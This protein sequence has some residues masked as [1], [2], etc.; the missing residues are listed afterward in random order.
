[1]AGSTSSTA[2]LKLYRTFST[3]SAS[4]SPAKS[5]IRMAQQ[6]AHDLP[7]SQGALDLALTTDQP[8]HNWSVDQV[9]EIYNTPLNTLLFYSQL[10]HRK[11][12]DPKE[13]QLCTLLSIKTGGCTEDCKYCAQSTRNHTG[14]KAEKLLDVEKVFAKAKEAK[15]MGSTRFCMGSAWREMKGRKSALR[16]IGNMVERIN[17]E[18]GM[19][20]CVTLGMI[21]DEQAKVLKDAGLT[22]YNHNID[23]SR[24][25]YKDIIST[26]TYDDRLKTIKAV[27]DANIGA[28]AGGILGLGETPQDRVSFLHTL[29]TMSKHPE[30]VPIN[31]LIAIKGT[32]MEQELKTK[33][34]DRKLKMEDIYRTVATARL[35]MPD[36]I[37]RLAAGRYTMR[38]S[39]QL[40]C[41]M[42]GV[43]AIFTGEKMLTTMCTGWEEDIGMLRRWGFVPMESFKKHKPSA[44]LRIKID[45]S[46]KTFDV[47]LTEERQAA[48]M[49]LHA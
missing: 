25:H 1:M 26:R 18:L 10:Q 11:H 24:E 37:V 5:A 46:Q 48:A 14:V 19:E 16:K 20:T 45:P 47:D 6:P 22:A 2:M 23:T 8:I 34:K 28:C 30:S 13:I 35:I 41:F 36:S 9:K 7:P 49:E 4:L 17:D 21:N 43:N 12:H 29:A 38:E 31:R 27:Q 32:P 44:K 42:S 15:E 33:Y 3:R 40:L 39:E